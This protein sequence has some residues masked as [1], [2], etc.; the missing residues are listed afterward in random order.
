[1]KPW[2][3][4]FQIVSYTKIGFRT[5]TFVSSFTEIELK[6]RKLISI[7][8]NN[9]IEFKPMSGVI[10]L[11]CNRMFYCIFGWFCCTEMRPNMKKI[12]TLSSSRDFLLSIPMEISTVV[13]LLSVLVV[14]PYFLVVYPLF[15]CL[16]L[17]KTLRLPRK[18][19]QNATNT[20]YRFSDN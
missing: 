13:Q 8:G 18:N 19:L 20:I 5:S 4:L 15:S 7:L 14:C 2:F 16:P 3:H 17:W 1:M 6:C 10:M 12:I 9:K 11:Q